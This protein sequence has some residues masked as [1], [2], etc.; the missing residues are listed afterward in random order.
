MDGQAFRFMPAGYNTLDPISKKQKYQSHAPDLTG[1]HSRHKQKAEEYILKQQSLRQNK[2]PSM[3]RIRKQ[4]VDATRKNASEINSIRTKMTPLRQPLSI[5]QTP[6]PSGKPPHLKNISGNVADIISM[7]NS[8]QH[9][10]NTSANV[11]LE[12]MR[13]LRARDKSLGEKR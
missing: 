10:A 9:G 11:G 8:N 5:G 13:G 7:V 3:L 6:D 4:S 1:V 2:Q 12:W